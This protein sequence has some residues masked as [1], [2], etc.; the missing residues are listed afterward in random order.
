LA[1]S[2]TEN[3]TNLYY[4]ARQLLDWIVENV[5]YET[6]A[7]PR[8]A[9]LTFQTKIGDCDDFSSLYIAMARAVGIPAKAVSGNAYLS[10]YSLG[11]AQ[12][13]ISAVGHAWVLIYLPDYGWVPADGVWPRGQGSFGE[14]DYA[15][16]AGA[17][18]GGSGVVRPSGEIYWPGPGYIAVPPFQVVLGQSTT[19]V[20]SLSSGNVMPEALLDVNVQAGSSVGTDGSLDFTV[21]VKNMSRN[22]AD[23]ISVTLDLDPQ[24]F[25]PVTAQTKSSLA[26]AGSWVASFN[27][28]LKDNAYG[29]SHNI[30][31]TATYTSSYSE[32][33]GQLEAVGT[34]SVAV[35]AQQPASSTPPGVVTPQ[36]LTLLVLLGVVA[37]V[38]IGVVVAVARR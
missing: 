2:L 6:Q 23:N 37:G 31:S 7:T 3:T 8:G 18:T 36:D 4:K 16:I 28:T 21:T 19:V 14:A 27:V 20:P 5:T 13:N 38:V 32:A 15:H 35:A 25:E 17:T 29:M 34:R 30:Q 9:L 12:A 1:T 33:A 24:Y 26:S 22:N 10:I 11:G